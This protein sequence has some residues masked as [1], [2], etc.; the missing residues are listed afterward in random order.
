MRRIFR[1]HITPSIRIRDYVTVSTTV[2]HFKFSMNSSRRT[3]RGKNPIKT[4]RN[5]RNKNQIKEKP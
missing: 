4:Y 2:K 5:H 1:P 3:A